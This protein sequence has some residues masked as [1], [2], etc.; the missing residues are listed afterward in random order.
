VA[1]QY[2]KCISHVMVKQWKKEG[3]ILM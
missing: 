3:K 1:L 2:T